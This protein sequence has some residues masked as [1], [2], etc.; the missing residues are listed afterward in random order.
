MKLLDIEKTKELSKKE[1][2]SIQGGNWIYDLFYIF[3]AGCVDEASASGTGK[4]G[5]AW[6]M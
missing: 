5:G 4:Y 6:H 1:L 3:A 2:T